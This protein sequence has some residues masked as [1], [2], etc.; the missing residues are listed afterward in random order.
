MPGG[1]VPVA[2]LFSVLP[3]ALL[4]RGEVGEWN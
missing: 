3:V 2:D 1:P 4:V